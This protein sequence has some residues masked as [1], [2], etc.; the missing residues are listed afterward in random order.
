VDHIGMD[1]HKQ[2]TQVCI[3]DADG[4]VVLEPRLRTTRERF[5]ALLGGRP[6]A[7]IL[8]EAAT[9]S[10]W[11]AQ[12]LE[13]LGHE[14]IVADPNYAAMYAT[15]SRRV[16]TDR[17]DARTLADACR[18]GAYHPAHR[19]SAAQREVGAELT[20]REALVRTRTRYLSV[21]R[22]LLRREGI[23]VP[24][25]SAATFARRLGQVKLPPAPQAAVAP[26]VALLVPLNAAI[27]AAD[28]Q[29][30]RRLAAD[31]VARRLAT[32]PGVGPVTAI[33]FR[34]TLDDVARFARPGQVAAYLGLVPGEY[35]S[36]ERQHRGAITKAGNTRVRWLLVQA[37]W[38]IWRDRHAPSLPLRTWAQRVAA[39]RGK[40]IAVVALA[41]RLAGIL[42]ALWRDGT[43]FDSARVGRGRASVSAAA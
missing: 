17:R 24:S 43:T 23:H 1:V 41:R 39:R 35:S 25:G 22:A 13:T 26:L 12:H 34:A 14:V 19:V 29:V 20:V 15:R 18:L 30:A 36:G 38:G 11:V 3:E 9:E 16:K 33:A 5:T 10:E 27:A 37:A 42:F 8:L 7:R 32:T 21:I 40:G 6:R 2:E 28:A 31:P 4:A